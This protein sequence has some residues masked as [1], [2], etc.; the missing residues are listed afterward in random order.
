MPD[1]IL[2]RPSDHAQR[3]PFD[4]GEL[5]WFASG[6]LGNAD[7]LTVGRCIL[8]PGRA[9]PRHYHPNCSEVLLVLSGRIRHTD[10]DGASREMGPEDTVTIPANI[11]HQAENIGSEDAVLLIAFS[12]ADR[13]TVG[14]D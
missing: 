8:R 12:S 2:I 5:T 3:I 4:W 6:P 13:Q 11:W 1:A 9:N 7:D 10:A 14:E